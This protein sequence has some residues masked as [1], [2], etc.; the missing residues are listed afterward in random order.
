M[1]EADVL[2]CRVVREPS[3]PEAERA[4]PFNQLLRFVDAP[5]L[6]GAHDAYHREPPQ[7]KGLAKL[8]RDGRQLREL[9]LSGLDVSAHHEGTERVEVT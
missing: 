8:M 7:L 2:E 3:L 5:D 6:Q 9:E 4:R 1:E